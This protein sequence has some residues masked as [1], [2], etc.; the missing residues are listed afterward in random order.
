MVPSDATDSGV[1][2][3]AGSPEARLISFSEFTTPALL[4]EAKN[5]HL[6]HL[7]DVILDDGPSGVTFALNILRDFGRILNG[8]TVSR[9][10]NVS[11]KWDGAPAVIFGTDPDDGQFFVATKGAFNK[12]PK[13]AKS[14]ADIDTFWSG[15]L[16]ETMHLAFN[17]LRAAK[18][19]GVLQGDA[20][21]TRRSLGV[22]TIDGVTYLVFRPNTITY[23]V[24][25]N[26][27]LGKRIAASQFG[28]VVHTMYTGRG[29]LANF[30]ASPVSPGAFST[31]R[32]GSD[33]VILDAAFDDL[34]GTVTFTAQE[35][36]DF[37]L[38][39]S[40]ASAWS[41]L[42]KRVF[43]MILQEP[44]HAYLQQFINAQVRQNKSYGPEEAVEAFIVWLAGLEDKELAAKKSEAGK[45]SVR[46]RF[47]AVL[48]D[49]RANK[50]GLVN[51]FALHSAIA[52]AKTVIV[53]KLGQASKVASFVQTPTGYSVTGPEGFVAVAHSG[54]AI[55]LVD[56]LE[57]SR[58]NFTVPKQ[59]A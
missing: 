22:E 2:Y 56:R 33:V 48:T 37:E 23:A 39:F 13:L 35:K 47:G 12:V 16:A 7:E 45:A 8:G 26:S 53:R 57:F 27:D 4:A 5:T 29:S 55:K 59:W 10:L 14:H 50:R 44:L 41:K 32:P 51:W 36:A 19:K 6:T 20:L 30:S 28:I 11:V 9:A 34:S 49:I 43:A 1:L 38:A 42:D 31:L 25:Q 15:G 58:L 3:E 18:P 40:E 17:T 21:Y 52:R 54:K 24:D 46:S